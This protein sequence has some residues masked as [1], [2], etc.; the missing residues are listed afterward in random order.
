MTTQ[1]LEGV[2]LPPPL[3][4]FPVTS[5]FQVKSDLY[6][7]GRELHGNLEEKLFLFD[8]DFEV[9]IS[10]RLQQ[11]HSYPEHCRL[12]LNDDLIDLE[13]C[14][15]QTA[16][17]MARDQADYVGFSGGVLSSKLLGLSLD[18][19][20]QL[21]FDE[22]QSFFPELSAACYEHLQSLE[23][24]DRLCDMLVFCAQED[25][26]IGRTL[27]DKAHD[28]M[29]CLLVALPSHWSPQDKIGLSFRDVHKPVPNSE[30]LQAASNRL[31][32][33]MS[34]KGPFVRYNWTF[35]THHWPRNPKT[36]ED[37]QAERRV[38]TEALEQD[39]FGKH[40]YFRTERQTLLAFPE[41][42][43][44]LFTIHTY[45]QPFEE[46]LNSPERWQLM[47]DTLNSVPPSWLAERH[48]LGQIALRFKD[49][50]RYR[51]SGQ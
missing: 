32:K 31:V 14:L 7:L 24:F 9:T 36:A 25:L 44:Y 22:Q 27:K 49:M 4:P 15:W 37:Y 28:E 45:I 46:A 23:G 16:A 5:P 30:K 8:S 34:S 51:A 21:A 29:E 10:E 20:Y 48:N 6:Q 39:S 12:Y 1:H 50:F 19:N 18:G 13:Y 41:R 3:Y 17:H 38:L 26:V 2:K 47:L 40:L 42:Q 11:L 43:R 33:A 35:S